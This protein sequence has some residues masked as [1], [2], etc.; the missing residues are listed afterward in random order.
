VAR[1]M[2]DLPMDVLTSSGMVIS[3]YPTYWG[4]NQ[5]VTISSSNDH[6]T[7]VAEVHSHEKPGVTKKSN[8]PMLLSWPNLRRRFFDVKAIG[9]LNILYKAWILHKKGQCFIDSYDF[10]G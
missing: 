1:S 2:A 3:L 4:C 7:T 8:H 6:S 9:S 5:K 10:S